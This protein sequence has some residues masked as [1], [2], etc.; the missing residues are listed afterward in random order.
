MSKNIIFL[1]TANL[2]TNPRLLKE[3]IFLKEKNLQCRII[4]FYQGNWS[5]KIDQEI[6]E[7]HP[8]RIKYLS[9]TRKPFFP[10]FWS[11]VIQWLS[12]KLYPFA[13]TNL[14]I[15]AFAHNKRTILLINELSKIQKKPDLIIAH[16]LGAL[17]PAWWL[18]KRINVPFAFD[19][20][21]YHPGEKVGIDAANEKHRR[22]FLMKKLLPESKYVSFAAPLIKKETLKLV[23]EKNIKTPVLINNSFYANEFKAP[24]TTKQAAAEPLKLVWFS[25]NITPGRGLEIILP[26]IEKFKDQV[27]LYLIGNLYQDFYSDVLSKYDNIYII[28]PLSQKELHKKL[29]EFDIGLALELN[30]A[31]YNRQICLTNKIWAYYQAGLY[32]LAT[33]TPAQIEF[34]KQRPDHGILSGQSVL[35][36]ENAL[37]EVIQS[38][39][40]LLRDVEMR[41][42]NAQLESWEKEGE[43]FLHLIFKNH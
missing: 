38:K 20:E 42:K 26:A 6:L 7:K 36:I 12:I 35:E 31:D 24:K 21:D 28:P 13:K 15:N 18:S 22:E 3:V 5:D 1:T 27:S 37:S 40:H 11:S 39:D 14:L 16:N 8:L 32:V 43:K 9:A 30:S 2:S 33:N 34:I 17:Y 29:S 19:V 23:G 25:Q 41:C 4:A 10:W